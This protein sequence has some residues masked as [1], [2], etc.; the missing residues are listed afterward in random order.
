MTRAATKAKPTERKGVQEPC[1]R[2]MQA[3]GWRVHR[4]NT[5]AMVGSHNG[6]SRF[7]RYGK[8]G[9]ADCYG[10]I[11]S[12]GNRHF[13]CEFKRAGERPTLDQVNWLIECHVAGEIAFWCDSI[14]QCR[15]VIEH[16]N[17]GGEIRYLTTTRSYTE[18]IKSKSTG[19]VTSEKTIGPSGDYELV[20]E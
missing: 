4:R 8:A 16:I 6:K 18:K 17:A 2:L 15:K 10:S 3:Y 14:D 9:M 7:V 5:G 13:E 11:K 19:K 20:F 1:M 12:R